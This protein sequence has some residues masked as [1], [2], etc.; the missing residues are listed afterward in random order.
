MYVCSTMLSASLA[1]RRLVYIANCFVRVLLAV[2]I[3]VMA[4]RSSAVACARL[5]NFM[6]IS[7]ALFAVPV[8]YPP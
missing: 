8:C 7:M 5:A 1:E 2:F 6:D 4:A 3:L